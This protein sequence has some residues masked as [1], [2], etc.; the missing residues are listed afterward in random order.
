MSV[1]AQVNKASID[2]SLTDL[3]VSFRNLAERAA[4]LSTQVNG[5]GNGSAFL[6]R[7]GYDNVANNPE[8]PGSQTDAAWALQEIAYLNTLVGVYHGAVRQ[9]GDGSAGSATTFDF[10][11][12]LSLLWSG[13]LG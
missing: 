3:A 7:A 4:R 5:Q 12:A 8:N 9:G 2:A 1:G 10:H 6:V 11:N 13:Q